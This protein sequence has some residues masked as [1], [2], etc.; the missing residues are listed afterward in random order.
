MSPQP[1]CMKQ[2]IPRKSASVIHSQ[3]SG[4]IASSIQIGTPLA[5]LYG[6]LYCVVR[7]RPDMCM[8]QWKRSKHERLPVDGPKGISADSAAIYEHYEQASSERLWTLSSLL[9]CCVAWYGVVVVVAVYRRYMAQ[10][11]GSVASAWYGV[12]TVIRPWRGTR[13]T[14][15]SR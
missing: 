2:D 11:E 10:Y 8:G 15:V 4:C 5:M 7:N 14:D 3:H 12:S 1:Y 13:V 6:R 9:F